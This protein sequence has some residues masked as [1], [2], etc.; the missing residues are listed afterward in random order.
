MVEN[1]SPCISLTDYGW[2]AGAQK[3]CNWGWDSDKTKNNWTFATRTPTFFS[4]FTLSPSS[5]SPLQVGWQAFPHHFICGW[6]GVHDLLYFPLLISWYFH[7][8]GD[9]CVLIWNDFGFLDHGERVKCDHHDDID[10]IPQRV[11]RGHVAL[12]V[13][14]SRRGNMRLGIKWTRE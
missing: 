6:M 7:L 5:L 8:V 9:Y 13:R 3:T 10:A 4:S 14:L 2:Q 12:P 1:T 11:I